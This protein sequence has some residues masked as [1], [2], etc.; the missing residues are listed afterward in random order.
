MA[1]GSRAPAVAALKALDLGQWSYAAGAAGIVNSVVA[2]TIAPAVVGVRNMVTSLQMNSDALGAA[3][4]VVIRN[5][6]A[7]PVLWRIKIPMAGIFSGM[8]INFS[9]PIKS[10]VNTLLEVVTLTA[11]VTGGVF[12]NAQGTTGT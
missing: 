2:V 10:S 3:T 8:N 12:F 6:A 4:E 9:D 1:D 7:G 5:G 11:S